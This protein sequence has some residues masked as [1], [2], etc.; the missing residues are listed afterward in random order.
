V[1]TIQQAQSMQTVEQTTLS[2][3]GQ[4]VVRILVVSFFNL[5]LGRYCVPDADSLKDVAV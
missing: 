5:V 3:M 4:P 1:F 2:D